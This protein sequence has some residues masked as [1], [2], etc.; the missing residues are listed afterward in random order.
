MRAHFQWRFLQVLPI[1]M[2]LMIL[3]APLTGTR[4]QETFR[5]VHV[6]YKFENDFLSF[7][8]KGTDK[9]YSGG[10]RIGIN[11]PGK[12]K[13]DVL[14]AIS[15]NVEIYTARGISRTVDM[16]TIDDYPYSGISYL[17]Y[18]QSRL[19]KD[20]RNLFSF[21]TSV[22]LTGSQSYGRE[23][24]SLMHK[25]IHY[26]LPMGWDGQIELGTMLQVSGEHTHSWYSGRSIKFNTIA[27]MEWGTL[28]NR[29]MV[30]TE[31]KIGRNGFPFNEYDLQILPSL[32]GKRSGLNAF[33]R[34]T[35]TGVVYNK[36]LEAQNGNLSVENGRYGKRDIQRVVAGFSLGASWYSRRM[37]ISLVQYANSREFRAAGAHKYVAVDIIWRFGGR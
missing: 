29:V 22:G 33:L 12:K 27:S 36:M 8:I 28:F 1:L 19:S 7:D 3:Q 5:G 23:M 18:R 37:G 20:K 9:Y 32:N 11:F 6:Y 2:I 21:G 15:F 30:G 25:L 16:L 14:H 31:V 26:R 10:N 13:P 17:A 24:Q 35:L 4:A 34:P